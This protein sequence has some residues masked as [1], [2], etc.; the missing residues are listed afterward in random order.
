MKIFGI[1][2]DKLINR[3]NQIYRFIFTSVGFWPI[4]QSRYQFKNQSNYGLL[5]VVWI[6]VPQNNGRFR[7]LFTN[8]NW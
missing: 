3:S 6:K 7:Y 5:P 4:L 2:E 8:V 1:A